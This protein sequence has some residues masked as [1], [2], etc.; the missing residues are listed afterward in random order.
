[1]A[2]KRMAGEKLEEAMDSTPNEHRASAQANFDKEDYATNNQ[3]GQDLSGIK[4]KEGIEEY[5]GGDASIGENDIKRMMDAGYSSDDVYNFSKKRGLNYNQH[6]Q[7]YMKGQGDYQI[8]KGS[9]QWGDVFGSS[10]KKESTSSDDSSSS[11]A[12]ASVSVPTGTANANAASNNSTI[13]GDNN[14]VDQSITQNINNSRYYGGHKGYG[15]SPGRSA[16]FVDRYMTQNMDYQ[17]QFDNK[18]RA[19]D[20]IDKADANQTINIDNL[21]QRIKARTTASRARSTAMAGDLFGDMYNFS[22][23]SFK[24]PEAQD[25]IETP[26][27]KKL[28]KI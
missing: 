1:M 25:P 24:G 5:Y 26:D 16:S 19:Q 13:N 15:D 6:G 22:P 7:K 10:D 12:E 20:S 2:K 27:F 3:Y 28:G 21:D 9:D 4:Y 23:E 8:G 14:N 17:K 11:K 18:G